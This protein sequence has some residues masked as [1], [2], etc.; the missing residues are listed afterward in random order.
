MIAPR[1]ILMQC[2]NLGQFLDFWAHICWA[3]TFFF[4]LEFRPRINLI[5]R[6]LTLLRWYRWKF[7]FIN[8]KASTLGTVDDWWPIGLQIAIV[9]NIIQ[10]KAS[11]SDLLTVWCWFSLSLSARI[12]IFH[13]KFLFIYLNKACKV[14]SL[15]WVIARGQNF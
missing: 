12:I 6:Q 8:C 5:Y 15:V 10:K 3:C 14:C 2:N 11:I 9:F 1:N 13:A 4:L 7:P